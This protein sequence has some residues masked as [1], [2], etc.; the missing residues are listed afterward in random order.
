MTYMLPHASTCLKRQIYWQRIHAAL[1]PSWP[2]GADGRDR[3]P[4]VSSTDLLSLTGLQVVTA[5]TDA[6]TSAAQAIEAQ[7][8]PLAQR[9]VSQLAARCCEA[10]QQ[11]RGISMTY[12]MT[13][14]AMPTRYAQNKGSGMLGWASAQHMHHPLHDCKDRA[15]QGCSQIQDVRTC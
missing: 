10:L 8:Q 6:L 15:H 12:R 5:V 3:C 14:K 7:G 1:E 2:A 11:L 13:A 4:D 9:L